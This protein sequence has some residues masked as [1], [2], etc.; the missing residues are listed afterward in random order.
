M[1]YVY[2]VLNLFAGLGAFMIGFKLLSE[3]TEKL[4]NSGLRRMFNKT[5]KNPMVGVLIGLGA[6][7]IIQSSSATTVMIVGFVN[8]GI[9]SLYQATAMI[10]GANV[11]TTI[12][13]QIAALKSFKI[14]TFAMAFTFIGIAMDMFSKKD[15]VKSIGLMLSGIGLV[16]MGLEFMS[17]AMSIFSNSPVIVSAFSKISNPILLMLIGVVVTAVVQSSSAVTAILIT[18]VESGLV[19][20]NGG[21]AILFAILGTNIGT[22]VTAMLS[23]ISANTNGKRAALIHVMF[24][25][26]G[27]LIYLV[28][29]LI[30]KDFMDLTF[31]SWFTNEGTQVA[32]FHTFFNLSCTI[33][34][35][36]FIKCF[37]WLAKR[38]IQEKKLVT[39]VAVRQTHLDLRMLRSPSV[40][41]DC[42]D[43]EIMDACAFAIEAVDSAVVGFV[44][45]TDKDSKR[46]SDIVERVN[47]M[48]RNVTEYAVKVSAGELS[49]SDEQKISNLHYIIADVVRVAELADN[50]LNHT[51][52]AIN[53]QMIFSD[54]VKQQLLLMDENIHKLYEK[55]M[56][57]Y[58]NNNHESLSEVD[59]LEDTI[60]DMRR[61]LV[62][63]HID[64]L[65]DGK[66]QPKS[67]GVFINLVGNLER[68][69]DHLH[70]IAHSVDNQS[71]AKAL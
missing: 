8:S 14:A 46:I 60:D 7:M 63:G 16:F 44:N 28:L 62:Q 21:N 31:A 52:K 39:E 17:D 20:G 53:G 58:I 64:R 19:I 66:C 57:A 35:L 3:N 61:T 47:E 5:S 18:M 45:S 1:Q 13:G 54:S 51:T 36:P 6:T 12:T 50:I 70:S 55:T 33:I 29:L 25:T 9:M 27:S 67:S 69:A 26:F 38:I 41:L 59:V 56:D 2:A 22:C 4:A 68:V 48:G 42:A 43:R 49:Y 11:G 10:M 15:K 23:A 30:W 24:N 37:V 65:G 71:G 40:A 34:F 32:M